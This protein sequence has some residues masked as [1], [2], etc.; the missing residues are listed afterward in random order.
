[1]LIA[2]TGVFYIGPFTVRI[3]LRIDNPYW[4]RYLVFRGDLLLG[5]HFSR[6]DEDCCRWLEFQH[7]RK[8]TVYA[9]PTQRR[10]HPMRL[11]P[12]IIEAA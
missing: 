4:P 6:P 5:P 7:V 2:E 8:R 1:M 12:N 9:E 10:R 11:Y 3:A